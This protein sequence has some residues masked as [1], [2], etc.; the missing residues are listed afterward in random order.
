MSRDIA[1]FGVRMPPDLKARLEEK[2]KANGRS[3]NAEIVARLDMSLAAQPNA[4]DADAFADQ[5]AEK[6]AARLR[7]K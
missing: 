2:A 7:N 4:P 1:P 3:L 6:V 5:V